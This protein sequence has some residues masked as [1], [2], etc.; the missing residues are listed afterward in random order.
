MAIIADHLGAIIRIARETAERWPI[1]NVEP[2]E[3]VSQAFILA[4]EQWHRYD[5]AR[6]SPY[7]FVARIIRPRLIETMLRSVGR[8][9]GMA[10]GRGECRKVVRCPVR[11][12]SD[13]SEHGFGSMTGLRWA[14]LPTAAGRLRAQ[15]KRATRRAK[16]RERHGEPGTDR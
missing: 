7:T 6:G 3:W 13:V 1:R 5:P 15:R 12:E 14:T 4:A 8:H 11:L 10:G 16:A 2:D 9:V